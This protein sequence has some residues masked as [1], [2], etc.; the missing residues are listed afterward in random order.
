MN[1]NNNND[2]KF[3]DSKSSSRNPKWAIRGSCTVSTAAGRLS[4]H[5]H[6]RSPGTYRVAAACNSTPTGLD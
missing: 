5:L 3:A 2:I 6:G 1:N 4:R